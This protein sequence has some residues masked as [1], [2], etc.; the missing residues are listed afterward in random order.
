MP[1]TWGVNKDLKINI[2]NFIMSVS[3]I[4]KDTEKGEYA[5]LTHR[6][7]L[8]I[9]FLGSGGEE[10]LEH[11]AEIYDVGPPLSQA[12][13]MYLSKEDLLKALAASGVKPEKIK[14]IKSK[15]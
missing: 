5:V 10:H 2:L 13:P 6:R 11:V 14:E 1:L 3:N 8:R 15:L 7:D 12:G 4:W 9:R